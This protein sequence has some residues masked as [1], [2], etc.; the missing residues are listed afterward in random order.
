[1]HVTSFMLPA[2]C[3]MLP[4]LCCRVCAAYCRGQNDG[5]SISSSSVTAVA[6]SSPSSTL[7]L[8]VLVLLVRLF[9]LQFSGILRVVCALLGT[10]KE[11]IPHDSASLMLFAIFDCP[12]QCHS[13]SCIQRGQDG[14]DQ[15]QP[16]RCSIQRR[17]PVLLLHNHHVRYNMGTFFSIA[18]CSPIVRRC[19]Q[20]RV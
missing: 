16:L 2:A 9:V 1:M 3:C 6:A 4:V 12:G 7:S 19:R 10:R 14:G 11:R 15:G 13:G 18:P 8:L 17:D 5:S 20:C